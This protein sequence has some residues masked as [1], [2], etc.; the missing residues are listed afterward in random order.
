MSEER[1]QVLTDPQVRQKIRRMA[2]QIYEGNFSE[3]AVVL[4]GIDGQ[5]YALAEWLERELKEIAPF[6]VTVVNVKLDKDMPEKSDV[7]LDAATEELRKKSIVLIDDVL[8]TGR[9]LIYAL[10][11]FL[12]MELK[13]IEVAVLVNRSNHRFPIQPNYTGY[14][15]STTLNEHVT[16]VLGKKSTVYLHA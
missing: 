12:K 13:K 10:K 11:P 7:T 5:G 4:A 3:K 14:D 8:N 6:A 15:L 2:Y 16:V 9:T 1:N